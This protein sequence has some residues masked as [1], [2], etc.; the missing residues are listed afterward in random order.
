MKKF[1]AFLKFLRLTDEQDRLSLTNIAMLVVITAM[2]FRPELEPTDLIAL[3]ATIMGYQFKRLKQ[4]PQKD[5]TEML[6]MIESLQTKVTGLQ[7]NSK[8]KK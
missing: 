6:Q 5:D 7:L 4:P 8:L 1:V 2:A 3:V